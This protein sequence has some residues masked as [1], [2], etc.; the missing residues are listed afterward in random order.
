MKYDGYCI[1]ST[2]I[3]KGGLACFGNSCDCFFFSPGYGGLCKTQMSPE[4]W[5]HEL[6]QWQWLFCISRKVL[7]LSGWGLVGCLSMSLISWQTLL[8]QTGATRIPCSLWKIEASI[9]SRLVGMSCGLTCNQTSWG[10]PGH[11]KPKTTGSLDQTVGF[12]TIAIFN[13][14]WASK[15]DLPMVAAD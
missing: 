10:R 2:K 8:R 7:R 12:P 9:W 6:K 3:N 14:Y 11:K 15:M 4:S 13:T 5:W 1:G